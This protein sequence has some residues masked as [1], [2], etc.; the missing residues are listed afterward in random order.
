MED[1]RPELGTRAAPPNSADEE[2]VPEYSAADS[3][4]FSCPDCPYKGSSSD[5]LNRHIESEHFRK[6]YEKREDAESKLKLEVAS[7]EVC[8]TLCQYRS[9]EQSAAITHVNESHA[10]K[11]MFGCNNCHQEFVNQ[12]IFFSFAL[13]LQQNTLR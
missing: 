5:N 8:C 10:L 13:T 9:T 6:F 12:V 3:F 4:I 11:S 2:K 7:G 1:I